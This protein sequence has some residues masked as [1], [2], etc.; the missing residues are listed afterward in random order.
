MTWKRAFRWSV[1]VIGAVIL[2]GVTGAYFALNTS[3]FHRYMLARITQEAQSATGGKVDAQR[4]D[5][6][7]SSMTA[8]LYGIVLHGTEPASAKPL[9]QVDKLT[10]GVK[11]HSLLHRKL[12]LSE[13][14]VAHP[15]ANI[16]IDSN[17]GS[18]IPTPPP[19]KSTPTTPWNLAIGHTELEGGEIYYKNQKAQLDADLYDLKTEIRYDPSAT[20]YSG[21]IS[22][23]NGRVRYA[24]YSPLAH[25]L[26]AQFKATPRGL[27][28]SSLLVNIG[29]SRI[30]LQGKLAD[31]D[32]PK[33]DAVYR[34]LVRTD[35][36]AALS[37]ELTPSGDMNLSGR[38]HYQD[39]PN[40]PLLRNLSVEGDMTSGDMRLVST[41]GR[42]QAHRLK[43]QYH[44]ANGD[45]HVHDIAA[46]LWNGQLTAELRMQPLD[47]ASNGNF[48]ASIAR[49]SLESARQSIRRA[50]VRRMPVTGTVDA[51]LDGNWKE[52]LKNIHVL[53]NAGLRAAI[54]S[55]AQN[56]RSATP[57]DGAIHMAYDARNNSVTFH[58]TTLKAGSTSVALEGQV[59]TRSN[60]RVHATA[61]DLHELAALASCL[62]KSAAET[63]SEPPVISGTAQLNAV[64][65][66][67]TQKPSITGQI[68]AQNLEVEGSDWK[69]AH[70]A[71]DAN[72]SVLNIE[73]M[74]LLNARQGKLT[75][76]GGVVLRNWS[77]LPS[78][79]VT[80]NLL[81]TGMS[82]TDLEHLSSLEYPVSGTLSAN[83]SI[84]GSQLNPAGQGSVRIVNA[85]AYN[86]PIENLTIQFQSAGESI[87]SVVNLNSPAGSASANVSYT[88][89]T[90]TYSVALQTPGIVLQKLQAVQAKHLPIAGTLHA[91]ANGTGTVDNP[92]LDVTL[93]I[94]T[95]QVQQTTVADM[96]AQLQV[97]DQNANLSLSS[98]VAQAFVQANATVRLTG[99]YDAQATIDTNKIPL[100]PLLALYVT[101]MPTG[102]HGETEVHASLKGPLK[103]KSH[104]EAH[105][106][107][108]TV[109]VSYQSLQF[110]NTGPIRADY[111][112]SVLVLNPAEI[113]GTD[114]SLRF[115]GR[116]PIQSDAAMNVQ[117]Q[118]EVNLSLLSIFDSD[119]KSAGE[120]LLDIH[121]DG[122]ARNPDVRGNV[123][124][125]DVALSTS[126]APVGLSKLNGTLDV[127]KDRIQITHLNGEI[128]GGQISAGG[129]IAYRPSLEFNVALQGKS[130]RLL[131]PDGLRTVLDSNLFFTGNLTAANLTGH[132]LID[133][134]NFT[135]DFDL[136]NFTNQFTGMSVPPSGQSFADNVRLAVS[137][138][139]A[140]NLAA[141]GSQLSL[142]GIAN[143]QIN[144][145]L[146]NPVM[147]GRVDLASGELFFINNRYQ[148]KRGIVT[149]DDP[150]HT[151]PVLNLQM[152]SNIQQYNLTLTLRGP[153]D[154][155][156]T[157][158]MSDPALPTADIISLIYR[159]ETAEQA[160]ANGTSTD[161]ILAS[162]VASQFSSSLQKMVG[163]SSLQIDPTIGA[164]NTNP[165]ARIAIQ[166]RVTKNFLFTFSTDV[167]QPEQEIVQGEYQLNERWSVSVTRDQLGGVSVD[168]RYHTRF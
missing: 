2:A 128:G 67:S 166:Q 96:K 14:L 89:K 88:P 164:N 111:S 64:V 19:T 30:W 44:L 38:I 62:R 76:S 45:L 97:R 167:T 25:S 112:N 108:P 98:N 122:S 71:L 26:D 115:Q 87:N 34:I 149:F 39:V 83:I 72:P 102:F 22:Y 53:C 154:K 27:S 168:G 18:N 29:S 105:L 46:D 65:Q 8:D 5:F 74:T 16:L 99:N 118:G 60:L 125:K 94:P 36:F 134:L 165:D 49:V 54:W 92:Q 104:L 40:Q 137:L 162:G 82:L 24:E 23:K 147:I 28:L 81:A 143:L 58:Q 9:L 31:Y 163:I 121:G 145:T 59:S 84:H 119:L 43:A 69:G 103:D 120:V 70:L 79:P 156:T 146:S 116:V 4:W 123:R 130:I 139:S 109:K 15:I 148:L 107:I 13:I 93:E 80:A 140:Q 141:R 155:L 133:S 95:L 68:D 12:E 144:G 114:T 47:T 86:Q 77:Y 158:Y 91:S 7:L 55:D 1:A 48:R 41:Q 159:G 37:P 127:T 142:E 129:S 153:V 106:T 136:V 85:T 21:S 157:S 73:H 160:S 101:G 63:K 132:V 113:R 131:Y 42:V 57:I 90:K 126:D 20:G 32:R 33:I 117:A 11:L 124:F 3:W 66:G 10:V 75:L 78:S 52:G 61:G 50:D 138:R 56:S 17:G 151:R 152:T 35:E 135:P 161:S 110:G 51:H 100:D 6:H 150:N